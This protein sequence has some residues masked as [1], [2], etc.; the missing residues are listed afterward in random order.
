MTTFLDGPRSKWLQVVNGTVGL[1]L[2][3][4]WGSG[5][6]IQRGHVC[7]FFKDEKKSE[8]KRYSRLTEEQTETH[9]KAQ[10]QKKS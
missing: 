5:G 3:M 4:G 8:G 7:S 6:T 9:K 10:R 2:V 1:S